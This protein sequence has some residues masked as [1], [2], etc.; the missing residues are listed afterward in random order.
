MSFHCVLVFCILECIQ[1]IYLVLH[2]ILITTPNKLFK[3]VFN[4]VKI[5]DKGIKFT[6][7]NQTSNF[8][9]IDVK[10]VVQLYIVS[11]VT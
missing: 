4:I 10:L 3:M 1:R 11:H 5:L 7:F 2:S 6:Y 9:E 8:Y